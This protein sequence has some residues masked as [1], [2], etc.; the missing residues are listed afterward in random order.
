MIIE[1]GSVTAITL[2]AG[3]FAELSGV[4]PGPFQG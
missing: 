3:Q 1:L 2:G 4:R